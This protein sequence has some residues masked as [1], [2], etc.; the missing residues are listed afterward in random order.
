MFYNTF[1]HYGAFESLKLKYFHILY[2]EKI[3]L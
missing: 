2:V 1:L 3:N